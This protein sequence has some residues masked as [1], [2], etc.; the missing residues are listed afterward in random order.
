MPGL[1][2]LF[3]APS[4]ERA[5]GV[6]LPARVELP[7]RRP[8]WLLLVLALRGVW[9]GRDELLALF[10]PEADE[11]AARHGL[12]LWLSRAKAIPWVDGLEIERQRLR[13]APPTDVAAF[14][15]A[16]GRGDVAEALAWYRA[17]L[18]SG[19]S[20]P[21]IPALDEWLQGE[22]EALQGAAREAALQV[23]RQRAD[24]GEHGAAAEIL[25]GALSHDP[26]AEQV[27]AAYMEHAAR[28]GRRDEAL[29]R[30]GRFVT[31][32]RTEL[33]VAPLESTQRVAAAIEAATVSPAEDPAPLA[34]TIPPE[35]VHP[36]TMVA[37]ADAVRQLRAAAKGLTIVTGEPGVG[38][39]R[40][41]EESLPGALWLRCREATRDVPLY[42]I[43]ELVPK[44]P[45][46]VAALGPYAAD[47]ARL[48]PELGTVAVPPDPFSSDVTKS[49]LFEGLARLLEAA[50][51]DLVVEDLHWADSLTLE[52]IGLLV[53]RGRLRVAA[54][55]LPGRVPAGWRRRLA[56]LRAAGH[57][58]DVHLERLDLEGVR[59]LL[60]TMI[61]VPEGPPRF[62]VWLHQRTGGNP[63]F[64]V[65]TLKM[66]R[67][68]GTLEIA[69]GNWHTELD[70]L[71]SD[72]SEIAVPPGVVQVIRQ[73]VDDVSEPAQRVLE[74]SSVLGEVWDAARLAPLV[75][76]KPW[77]VLLALE[78]LEAHGLLEGGGFSHDLVRTALYDRLG[79]QRCAH[80]HGLAA[81]ACEGSLDPWIVADHWQ[82]AKRPE[83]AAAQFTLAGERAA[84]RGW[85]AHALE[86]ADRALAL[87][88]DAAARHLKS[89]VLLSTGRA[90][91]AE[92]LIAA[93]VA[94][95]D[96]VWQLRGWIARTH[97]AIRQGRLEQAT[98]AAR[99]A[100]E[101][102]PGAPATPALEAMLALAN[103]AALSGAQATVVDR[104]ERAIETFGGEVPV[105]L[106]AQALSNLAWLHTGLGSFDRALTL[107]RAASMLARSAGDVYWTVWIAANTLYCCLEAGDPERALPD[108]ERALTEEVSDAHEILRINLAKAYLDLGR[109]A[110][111]TSLLETLLAHGH[112]PS[113]RAVALGYLV[114]LYARAGD[115][116]R[117]Q[118][119]LA[120]AL[121]LLHATDLDRA[122][123]R[124]AIAALRHGDG[125]QR[126]QVAPVVSTLRRGAVPGYV[127]REFAAVLGAGGLRPG[128]TVDGDADAARER[129]PG[130]A[131]A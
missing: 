66:L 72:Y 32:L 21:D 74:M 75:D 67:E 58:G 103:T 129:V 48:V 31:L 97:Q 101:R 42:P 46:V 30:F 71:T 107:Y 47:V 16:V 122:R 26:L 92:P 119:A 11:G 9:V 27:L 56:A 70:G 39:S 98:E 86:A 117:S 112:D 64:V 10:W 109:V 88:P 3:G 7:A 55:Q 82:R 125:V 8:V 76:M 85:W 116:A 114:E 15:A 121:D 126:A 102:V 95:P 113:N 24:R 79:P 130:E 12:R 60:A 14:R 28:A 20:A 61:G 51:A 77:G 96:A 5:A 89:S 50:A 120:L 80:L 17:P 118:D 23:A 37:R 38:K 44:V 84:D 1:L 4:L 124:I 99:A 69:D 100:V 40:L 41:L 123:M 25:R 90:D 57:V 62:S 104:L 81:A 110:D 6:D 36:P 94:D 29:R 105:R 73:R 2:R 83:R 78:E 93:L 53:I 128:A 111:A 49:R 13:W 91:D 33:G 43:I 108:A 63:L 127:W 115:A 34:P 18:L 59:Q 22:R 54:S 65:E 35:M 87:A 45:H 106:R 19:V 52:L 68:R 131:V